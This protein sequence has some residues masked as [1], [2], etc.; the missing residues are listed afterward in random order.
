[1]QILSNA[2]PGFRDLRGP[3]IAGYMW[4]V[5]AWLLVTPDWDVRPEDR[6]GGGLYDLG[7]HVGRIWVAVAVSVAAYLIGSI[8]QEGSAAI[9]RVLM[10]DKA[11][12]F[13]GLGIGGYDRGNAL[14]IFRQ[15]EATLEARG[16]GVPPE[17]MALI[18]EELRQREVSAEEE[19]QR[20]LSLPATL[21]VGDRPEL[22]AEVDRLRAE[23]EL[24]LAVV[25]P[26][27]SLIILLA[28]SNSPLWILSIPLVVLLLVQGMRREADSRKIIADAIAFGRIDSPSLKKFATWVTNSLPELLERAQHGPLRD[29]HAPEQ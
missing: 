29:P 12:A 11:W 17:Q 28:V 23:G 14:T 4:L 15:G 2:L 24:R 22:F 19:A 21:L 1:M 13:L 25:P 27:I 9:R 18:D 6:I 7:H 16:G 8:S 3:I 26:M 5:F 20:E 10:S